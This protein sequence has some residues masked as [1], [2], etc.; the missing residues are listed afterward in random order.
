MYWDHFRVNFAL[1]HII[2][3]CYQHSD[4]VISSLFYFKRENGGSENL[5][6]LGS[7]KVSIWTLAICL[8]FL[9]LVFLFTREKNTALL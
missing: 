8:V 2:V 5:T 4:I 3:V 7:G 9:S 6:Q 1:L